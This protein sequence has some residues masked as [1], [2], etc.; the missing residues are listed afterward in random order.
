MAEKARE[1]SLSES[2]LSHDRPQGGVGN[3]SV[4][5]S[6]GGTTEVEVVDAV[7]G[8]CSQI[9][10]HLSD[11]LFELVLNMTFNYASTNVRSNAVHA[12]HQ[13]VECIANA[14]PA[15]TLVKFLPFCAVNIHTEIKHGASSV[16][17]TSSSLLLPSDATLS[18][19]LS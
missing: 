6:A 8:A 5:G 13:L 4:N 1:C 17:M 11:S 15:K 19:C 12:I 9:C 18:R 3:S 2:K 14:H 7:T 16:R 10:V